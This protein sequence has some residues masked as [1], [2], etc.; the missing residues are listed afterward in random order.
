M[1]IFIRDMKGNTKLIDVNENDT[2]LD[3][4]RK[5]GNI[6]ITLK[7]EGDILDN[8]QTIL[9]YEIEDGNTIIACER[10]IGGETGSAAKG[11]ADPT[12]KDPKRIKTVTDGPFY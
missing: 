4:K 3:V 2:I 5:Y 12:K 7:F 9:S 1:R 10:C 8:N 6:N 11:L